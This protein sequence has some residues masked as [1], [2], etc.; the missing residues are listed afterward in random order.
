MKDRIK[1]ELYFHVKPENANCAQSVLRGFQKELNV[2]ENL[3]EKFRS[4]GGGRAPEG[5]CGALF[6]AD[7]LLEKISKDSIQGDFVQKAGSFSCREIRRKNQLSCLQC[8]GMADE[9]LSEKLNK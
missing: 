5:T 7:F 3:I 2:P 4:Y 6:A 9:L 8:V 1:S